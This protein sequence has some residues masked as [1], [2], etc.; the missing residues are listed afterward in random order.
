MK[1][2]GFAALLMLAS[3]ATA[4][5]PWKAPDG[6][7]GFLVSCNDPWDTVAT[8][9]DRARA[10]CKGNYEITTT[11]VGGMGVTCST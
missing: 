5:A 7:A 1:K 4:A 11:H 9:Y 3:C 2:L 8:C 6:R 10:A